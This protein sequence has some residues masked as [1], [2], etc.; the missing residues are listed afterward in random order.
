MKTN[1]PRSLALVS[2]YLS[3]SQASALAISPDYYVGSYSGVSDSGSCSLKV[4]LKRGSDGKYLRLAMTFPGL[5]AGNSAFNYSADDVTLDTGIALGGFELSPEQ[6]S[7]FGYV[8]VTQAG[9]PVS[10]TVETKSIVI[11]R[12]YY[13]RQLVKR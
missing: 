1:L 9:R 12:D 8:A 10:Y 6:G 11:K 2:A 7:A 3:L 5:G 4:E 13:C